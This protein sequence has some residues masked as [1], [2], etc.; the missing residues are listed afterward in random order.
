MP[1]EPDE[2]MAVSLAL[3]GLA[4]ML[5]IIVGRP[6][7]TY[8][9][10][11][12][13]GKQVRI[14]GPKTQLWKSGTPTMGG[15]MIALVVILITAVFN[16][17]GRLSMLL[18][19]GILLAAAILGAVDDRM[20]LVG[21]KKTGM[22][23]RFKMAWLVLFGTIAAGLLNLQT[24]G[25]GLHHVYVP[26]LGRFD[27]RWFYL[28]VAAFVIVGTAN[29]VNFADGL[30]TLAAG[31]AAIAF[32]AYG[33]IAYR[34]GQVGVVTFCFT[35][36]GSLLGFLWFNAHPAQVFHGRHRVAGY[37]IVAGGGGVHDRPMV[38]LPVVGGVFVAEAVSVI[39]QVAYFKSTGGKRIF[40]MTPLHHH[41]EMSG[42][43]ETQITM[44]FWIVGMMC[45]L[46]GVA[47][48]LL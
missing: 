19:I 45:G 25:L 1:T 10:M 35:M 7:V 32:V 47:L 48:A 18:P 6:I 44:R 39:L 42:W 9:R 38:L 23:A 21:G 29:A 40:K 16:V 24:I 33:V 31:L 17:A 3:A 26:F 28:P 8:L 34:Q 12:N 41:F 11:K 13:I 4:F 30:D 5:T 43:S 27:M 14:D 37:R 46:I 15:L 22:T 2:N 20:N 36:V